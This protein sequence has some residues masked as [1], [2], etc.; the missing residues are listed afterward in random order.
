MVAR[1]CLIFLIII[2]NYCWAAPASPVGFWQIPDVDDGKARS[3][4][5]ISESGQR[6][7]GVIVKIFTRP[8]EP[9]HP[10]CRACQ[11]ELHN[12]PLEGLTILSNA[13]FQQ[14]SWKNGTLL[15]P[16]TGQRYFCDIV[17]QGSNTL[18][19]TVHINHFISRTQQWQ[20]VADPGS[21]SN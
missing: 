12:Q 3:I 16:R 20:R 5:R 9:K 10:V 21:N 14:N 4:V 11:G 19:V 8:H 2:Q 1:L 13:Q 7:S 18:R 17:M 6:L 15:M